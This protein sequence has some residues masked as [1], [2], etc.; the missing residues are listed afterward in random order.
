[1]K[2]NTIK[3]EKC[4]LDEHYSKYVFGSMKCYDCRVLD[5][6]VTETKK[7][8]VNK[9]MKLKSEPKGEWMNGSHE[10]IY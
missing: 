9:Y 4:G 10:W 1:M 8:K 3:C 7:K 5:G 2:S 6:E